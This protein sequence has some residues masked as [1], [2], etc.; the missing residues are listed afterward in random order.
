MKKKL[1]LKKKPWQVSIFTETSLGKNPVRTHTVAT[2]GEM[3]IKEMWPMGAFLVL[4][5]LR[6]F[7]TRLM[8]KGLGKESTVS[9]RRSKTKLSQ[10]SSIPDIPKCL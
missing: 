7:R 6:I 3:F 2:E 10:G 4:Q 5:L 8:W 1:E 9:K